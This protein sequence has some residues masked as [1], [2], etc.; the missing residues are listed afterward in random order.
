MS[1]RAEEFLDYL[2]RLRR[3]GGPLWEEARNPDEL[4]ALVMDPLLLAHTIEALWEFL[5]ERS[6]SE[7]T[8]GSGGPSVNSRS[9]DA[10]V[11]EVARAIAAADLAGT[12]GFSEREVAQIRADVFLPWE[13]YRIIARA[14]IGALDRH[15]EKRG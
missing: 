14:A 11:E 8:C 3:V 15:R 13:K 5:T 7:S 4:K 12:M 10:E 9:E 2:Y 6:I 1:A